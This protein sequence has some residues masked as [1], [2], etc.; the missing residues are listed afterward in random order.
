MI[1]RKNLDKIVF[2]IKSDFYQRF[3][4]KKYSYNYQQQTVLFFVKKIEDQ[5]LTL[6]CSVM[7]QDIFLLVDLLSSYKIFNVK[8]LNSS[9]VE[10]W[11]DL[12]LQNI[13]KIRYKRFEN[14]KQYTMK[15]LLIKLS[16][17]IGD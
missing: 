17:K 9:A 10:C 1:M 16:N 4:N 14:D 8:Q 7:E 5:K 15:K 11:F 6:V 12:S 13:N 2:T 3:L